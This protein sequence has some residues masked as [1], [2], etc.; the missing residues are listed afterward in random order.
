MAEPDKSKKDTVR[1]ALP[2]EPAASQ[3]SPE[4]PRLNLPARPPVNAQAAA[5]STANARQ[6]DQ[7]SAPRKET[8][9][10]ALPAEPSTQSSPSMEMKKTQPLFTMPEAAEAAAT[11]LTVTSDAEERIET[12]PI[13]LCWAVLAVSTLLLIIQI[14]NYLS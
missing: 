3:A 6:N 13:A 5:S 8:A 1:I 14:W 4:D 9:R 2:G 12:I 7:T 11:P 10:V